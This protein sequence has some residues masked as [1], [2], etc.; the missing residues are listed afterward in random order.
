MIRCTCMVKL[1][2]ASTPAG[3]P[4]DRRSQFL[5]GSKNMRLLVGQCARVITFVCKTHS[6]FIHETPAD[7]GTTRDIGRAKDG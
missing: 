6:C 1:L 3:V 2:S 7:D 4:A 5:A